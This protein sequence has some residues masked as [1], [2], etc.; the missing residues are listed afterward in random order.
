M[1]RLE[2]VYILLFILS[3][4]TLSLSQTQSTQK[5]EQFKDGQTIVGEVKFLGLDSD[6]ETFEGTIYLS[7]VLKEFRENQV[8]MSVGDRFYYTNTEKG[9]KTLKEFLYANGYPDADVKVLGKKLPNNR[10][11]IIFEVK[12]GQKKTVSEIS[13]SGLKNFT[14]EELSADLK[15]CGGDSL[16]IYQV[17]KFEYYLY[18][19]TKQY[20]ASKGY[21][22]AKIVSKKAMPTSTGI[23]VTVQIS[24][25]MRYRI[26]EI[27]LNGLHLFKPKEI[28]DALGQSEGEI[29][30]Y[31]K[32]INFFYDK[33]KEKY[34]AKGYV[35][36]D[37]EITPEFIKPDIDGLDGTVNISVD[38]NEGKQFK[39]SNVRIFGVDNEKVIE[40][41][42]MLS[43]NTGDFYN[44]S[45]LKKW[46]EKIN[47]L[48]EFYYVN[49]LKDVETLTDP[50][51]GEVNILLKVKLIQ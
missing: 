11:I 12:R 18:K 24:E 38:I 14:N 41:R 42:K 39:M 51:N 9:L 46:I 16:E 36:C 26:G 27:K 13:F 23:V 49:F 47:E 35:E 8:N 5:T 50:E 48:H 31:K 7:H 34:E 6:F 20:L 44:V 10:I 4:C 33:L 32:F 40:L 1:K 45:E 19:C 2:S 21:L 43:L 17:R 3:A 25:G 29:I 28:L 30:D 37:I 15:Q 22:Q